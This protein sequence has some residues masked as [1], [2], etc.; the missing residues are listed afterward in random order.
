MLKNSNCIIAMKEKTTRGKN[1]D[2][3]FFCLAFCV[4]VGSLVLFALAWVHIPANRQGQE[5][6][7]VEKKDTTLFVDPPIQVVDSLQPINPTK[8]A[9]N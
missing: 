3:F 6:I 9:L 7:K 5:E 2:W 8:L 4:I 1:T